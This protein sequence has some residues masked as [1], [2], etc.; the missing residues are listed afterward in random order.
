VGD[1]GMDGFDLFEA[2][3][4]DGPLYVSFIFVHLCDGVDPLSNYNKGT[5]QLA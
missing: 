3:R 1:G 4:A 5:L 2:E